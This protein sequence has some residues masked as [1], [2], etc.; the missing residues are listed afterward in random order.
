MTPHKAQHIKRFKTTKKDTHIKQYPRIISGTHI[1]TFTRKLKTV[2]PV[3]IR[4][5]HS[6]ELQENIYLK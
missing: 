3:Y 5:L 1:Q 4:T 2:H 6:S